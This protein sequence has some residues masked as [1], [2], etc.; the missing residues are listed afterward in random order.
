MN[1][2]E[3][4]ALRHILALT[5]DECANWVA[6]DG[7]IKAW[8]SWE[9]GRQTIPDVIIE[10]MLA[11]RQKR[12]MHINAIIQKINHRIGNNTMRVFRDLETFRSVY[13]QGEFLD[14]K[15]YQSVAAELYSHDL[16][17]LSS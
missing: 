6:C 10:K 3:L 5:I 9:E 2:D 8:Q 14:W 4:Q 1:A 12:I 15:I 11:I 13:S 7:D 17:R 16:E